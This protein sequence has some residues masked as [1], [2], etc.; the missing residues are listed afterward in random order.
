L[1]AKQN[2]LKLKTLDGKILRKALD[3]FDHI[4]AERELA[5]TALR[6]RIF[7]RLPQAFELDRKI[8]LA[9]TDLATLVLKGGNI[10]EIARNNM[11]YQS[12]LAEL[13]AKNGYSPDALDE[14]PHCK[15][16]GDRGYIFTEPCECLMKLYR[17][18]QRKELSM[19]LKIGEQTFETFRLTY[20]PAGQIRNI[21]ET[22]YREAVNYAK[23]FSL[24]SRSLFMTGNPGLGK[25]FL[26]SCIAKEVSEQNFSV[27]YETAIGLTGTMNKLQFSRQNDEELQSIAER[28]LKCDLLILDDLGTEMRTAFTISAV[29]D[30][31]N[32][33]LLAKRPTIV[34]SNFNAE[35]I[36]YEYSP[37]IAS[38]LDGEFQKW[39]FYG[40]DIRQ[41]RSQK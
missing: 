1:T 37:Q 8:R 19:L 18:E 3:R 22:I 21:M 5:Q 29:Y 11:R 23:T 31:L 28:Y 35:Q 6:E 10:D 20:Y 4:N 36:A 38:R 12:E 16:C 14:I 24:G 34:N 39:T 9:S 15:L 32:S 13:L 17:E 30:V 41:I 2:W 26:S 7:S 40:S 25:T 27:V 33:R